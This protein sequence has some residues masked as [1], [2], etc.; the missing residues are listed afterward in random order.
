MKNAT[1]KSLI[2][3]ALAISSL[4]AT[5]QIGINNPNPDA[6][7]ILEIKSDKFTKA[8]GLL[9]PSLLQA[10]REEMMNNPSATFPYPAHSLLVFDST[11]HYFTYFD[12]S[13]NPNRWQLLSPWKT[14]IDDGASGT[15]S[16]PYLEWPEIHTPANI[17]VGIGKIPE[18][19]FMLNVA[20]NT[21]LN[22][23]VNSTGTINASQNITANGY[24]SNVNATNCAGPIP[25][26]GIIMWSGDTADIPDGWALCDGEN[27]TP[28]LRARFIVGYD[29]RIA[30]LPSYGDIGYNTISNT[31]GQKNIPLTVANIPSHTHGAGTL[32]TLSAGAHTHY[33]T[34]KYSKTDDDE[35]GANRVCMTPLAETGSI[36]S[37]VYTDSSGVHSHTISGSTDNGSTT[38]I[39]QPHENRP[40][41]YVLAFIMKK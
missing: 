40:P 22:G 27:G 12:E 38:L 21:L 5:A 1:N 24:S 39:G 34:N 9:I 19:G 20:G 6:S 30:G 8:G 36:P 31:G 17:Q 13:V 25:K 14:G 35:D 2:G 23:N 10:N 29:D 41:Y 7:A 28:D 26:G 4:A 11:I 15:K 37:T 18:S 32:T 3:L 33:V 16:A